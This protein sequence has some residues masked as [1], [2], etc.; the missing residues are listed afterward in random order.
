MIENGWINDII[1][2]K[3]T[4]R[5]ELKRG[6]NMS[7][8]KVTIIYLY[9]ILKKYSDENH[10]L[11]ADD[12]RKK[13]RSVYGVDMERRAIYRN[14]E[15][16]REL[17][18]EIDGYS[19]NREGYYL[20]DR[21][22]ETSDV[23]LLC[24]AV[25]ASDIISDNISKDIMGKLI[26]T[27]SVYESRMLKRLIYVKDSYKKINGS[28]F[29][30][31]D[32]L[33]VAINQGVKVSVKEQIVDY[34]MNIV[35][36]DEEIV[37][38]PYA[39]CWAAGEYYLIV[40]REGE[41]DLSHLRVNKI[42]EIKLLELPIEMF[43]GGVNPDEYAKRYIINKGEYRLA[44][45]LEISLKLWEDAVENFGENISVKRHTDKT[46]KIK[47]NTIH[48]KIFEY[49]TSH[50]NDCIVVSPKD[51][52]DEIRNYIYDAYLKYW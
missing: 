48:S 27:Q 39:T 41:S 2:K 4:S 7:G 31:L 36:M 24:D 8:T 21:M 5:T 17:D 19:D 13:L 50:L 33:S 35:S 25:A 20:V 16:L 51:F 46:I 49:V 30:N 18:I 26:D 37:V 6:E 34:D 12:I 11:S 40:K 9:E 52:K 29:Y 28:L 3:G 38:S 47:I 15:A 43:F 23:R 22:F 45:E 14:I 1:T 44:Y 42:S 10:I 32:L